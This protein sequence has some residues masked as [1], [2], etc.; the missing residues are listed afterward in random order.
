M[1]SKPSQTGWIQRQRSEQ[2]RDADLPDETVT[3]LCGRGPADTASGKAAGAARASPEPWSARSGPHC[4]LGTS[5]LAPGASLLLLGEGERRLLQAD[6]APRQLPDGGGPALPSC[7]LTGSRF[8]LTLRAGSAR[9]LS[10]Q[11]PSLTW[12]LLLPL[13]NVTVLTTSSIQVSFL[14]LAD[15]WLKHKPGLSSQAEHEH[16]EVIMERAIHRTMASVQ[17]EPS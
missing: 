9:S 7:P 14:I 13:H 4:C 11:G 15:T 17:R 16:T 8:L 3:P 5:G 10:T 2:R 6:R 1:I 12:P